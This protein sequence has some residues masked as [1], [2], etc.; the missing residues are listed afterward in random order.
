MSSVNMR[1]YKT[2]GFEREQGE[3]RRKCQVRKERSK[4]MREDIEQMK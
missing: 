3:F 4:R 2:I 1:G